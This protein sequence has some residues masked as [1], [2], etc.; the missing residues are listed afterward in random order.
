MR[1]KME[2]LLWDGLTCL[3]LIFVIM[4]PNIIFGIKVKNGFENN[5][6]NKVIECIEQIG[7]VSCIG[8]LTFQGLG[9]VGGLTKC[10]QF[11]L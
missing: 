5:Y 7:R 10:L 9:L 8:F 6:K 11:I 1:L 3:V 2:M 4:I